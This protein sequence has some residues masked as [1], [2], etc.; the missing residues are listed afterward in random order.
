MDKDSCIADTIDYSYRYDADTYRPK[1]VRVPFDL[2][3]TATETTNFST[4]IRFNIF[5]N[6]AEDVIYVQSDIVLDNSNIMYS[7]YD[8]Q[9]RLVRTGKLNYRAIPLPPNIEKGMY[10]LQLRMDKDIIFA[11]LIM[12][13]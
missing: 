11:K 13:Q 7:L 6:P 5:P 1:F 10:F 2:F 4:D 12:I 3:S 8:T 9:A